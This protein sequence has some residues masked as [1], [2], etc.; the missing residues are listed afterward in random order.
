MKSLKMKLILVIAM[1]S[2]FL[3]GVISYINFSKASIVLDEQLRNTAFISAQDNSRVIDEWL[4]GIVKEANA[5][6]AS[7][8]IQSRDPEAYMPVL[9]RVIEKY[10]EYALIY[11]TDRNGNSF[12][13][14]RVQTNYTDRDYFQ[15]AM[16]G[17]PFIS[18]PMLGKTTGEMIFVVAVPLYV[19]SQPGPDGIVGIVVRV[20][21]LQQ[22]VEN[23]KINGYGY[24]F[25]QGP[26]M[27]TYAHPDDELIDNKDILNT[28]DESLVEILTSMSQGEKGHATYF[29]QGSEKIIAYAPVV[30]TGW[31]IAQTAELSDVLAP[32][33]SIRN[34]NMLVTFAGFL[35]M[36]L[37]SI[38]IA[39]FITKPL[40]KLSNAAEI[41]AGGDL[42][43]EVVTG[44]NKDEIGVLERA[45]KMM[46][47]NLKTMIANIQASSD[48]LASYSQEL[49]SS[50]EEVSTNIE[51]MAKTS[52][53]V[54]AAAGRG[55]VDSK[56]AV[57]EYEQVQAV[58]EEGNQAVQDTIDGMNAIAGGTKGVAESIKNLGDKSDQIGAII[59]TVTGI[60][61]QTNLL[62]LNAAIEAARAG[63]HGKGFA[64]V[65]EEVRKL[66]G[67][68][69]VA[70]VEI[71]QLINDIQAE[72]ARAV[73]L[74]HGQRT[75]VAGGVQMAAQAGVSLGQI[76]KVVEKNI[77]VIRDVAAGAVQAD[78]GMQ[79]LSV[80][81]EQI[82]STVQQISSAAK[83]L[84][85][86]AGG[87]RNEAVKFRIAKGEERPNTGDR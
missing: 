40:A 55:V 52:N 45:F 73:E 8:D 81:N 23:M 12:G 74:I 65:A 86:I 72:V 64:V 27:T 68:S 29:Y 50:S 58:A 63:E 6:A 2:V 60:A 48:K 24:G 54:A 77:F 11:A 28:G 1:T 33:T 16:K 71:S 42:T 41:I 46:V 20:N 35:I 21:Y 69:A 18:N 31:T 87:L 19:E 25:I 79:H 67:Q 10:D 85:G 30:S 26:D 4:K 49:A 32:L 84:A 3:L 78:E 70:T 62:A 36:V 5:L 59:N 51:G 39:I 44:K 38:G 7:A 47:E 75:R 53:Q 82:S 56:Q 37:I 43:G 22:L 14:N 13:T 9:D 17:E 66:A 61:D 57:E 76:I 34:A 80:S 83:E 15:E